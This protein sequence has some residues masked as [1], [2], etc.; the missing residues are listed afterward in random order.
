MLWNLR[1]LLAI[2]RRDPQAASGAV[3]HAIRHFEQGNRTRTDAHAIGNE[4]A[5]RYEWMAMLHLIQLD[6]FAHTFSSAIEKLVVLVDFSREN[7]PGSL[8]TSLSTLAYVHIQNDDPE[9]ALPLLLESHERLRAEYDPSV[10]AQV[11]KMLVRCYIEL[12][13]E[14]DA[15]Q[16]SALPAHFWQPTELPGD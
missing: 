4:E 8:H 15:E 10:I 9:A 12:G 11:R 2:L 7:D 16:V 13:R 1:G 14:K 6:I 5:R 3:T